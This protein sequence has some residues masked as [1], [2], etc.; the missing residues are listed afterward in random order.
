MKN[1]QLTRRGFVGNAALGAAAAA[2]ASGRSPAASA[3]EA[4]SRARPDIAPEDEALAALVEKHTGHEA[5]SVE[6]LPYFQVYGDG[7][8][9]NYSVRCDEREYVVRV[10]DRAVYWPFG[11][12]GLADEYHAVVGKYVLDELRK[13]GP[14]APTVYA[15]DRDCD[16]M[17]R[18]C[19]VSAR[20]PGRLWRHYEEVR[21]S[22]PDT[23]LPATGQSMGTFLKA[24]HSIPAERGFGPM[25]DDGVG[26]LP[27]YV[28]FIQQAHQT[29]AEKAHKRGNLSDEEL[30]LSL[31]LIDRWAPE[32]DIDQG[33]VVYFCDIMFFALV[34]ALRRVVTGVSHAVEAWS[35]DPDYELEWFAY[36]D[37][38]RESPIVPADEFAEGYGRPYNEKSDKRSFLRACHYLCQLSWYDP[39]RKDVAH[40]RRK[41]ADILKKL[42]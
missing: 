34:D 24:L 2:T 39:K 38:D 19:A 41:L 1:Q 16:I 10:P 21:K 37:E 29:W 5:T 13:R 8:G 28:D 33:H 14:W 6:L 30:A 35:A 40:H 27:D 4:R 3:Q 20:L 7:R 32:C 25:N 23:P 31:D 17:D 15:V 42:A 18:P 22:K 11:D 9:K 26:L 36:Y 12:L